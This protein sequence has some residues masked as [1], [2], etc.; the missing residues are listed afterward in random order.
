MDNSLRRWTFF[1]YSAFCLC[2]NIT[3]FD[4]FIWDFVSI[5]AWNHLC[6]SDS[7]WWFSALGGPDTR[8]CYKTKYHPSND[9]SSSLKFGNIYDMLLFCLVFDRLSANDFW[10]LYGIF[11]VHQFLRYLFHIQSITREISKRVHHYMFCPASF[12]PNCRLHNDK[13]ILFW[14]FI[15]VSF[16]APK[17]NLIRR[18]KILGL[19]DG[20]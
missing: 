12:V 20:M 4:V 13:Y 16:R 9:T 11:V 7:G 1:P 3:V 15:F 17:L 18:A 14:A 19:A 10:P 5:P 8:N 6:Q 2:G